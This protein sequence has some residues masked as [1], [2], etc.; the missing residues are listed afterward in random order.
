MPETLVSVDLPSA[1]EV[2]GE[3]VRDTGKLLVLGDNGRLYALDLRDDQ[4]SPTE[5]SD[6]WVVDPCSLHDTLRRLHQV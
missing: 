5:L 3:H 1:Y 6:E 4:P 2:V